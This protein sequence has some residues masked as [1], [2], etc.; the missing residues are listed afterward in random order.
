MCLFRCS[1]TASP[2]SEETSTSTFN[3]TQRNLHSSLQGAS[4]HDI[5]QKRTVSQNK[6]TKT[7][8]ILDEKK[9]CA[10]SLP[11][12]FSLKSIPSARLKRPPLMVFTHQRQMF[13]TSDG[14]LN[15]TIQL[16]ISQERLLMEGDAV[17]SFL[18]VFF[19]SLS[20]WIATGPGY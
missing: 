1:F 12:A 13:P 14:N 19:M 5:T 4:E 10:L 11:K 8:K 2:L 6:P 15:G 9:V 18:L 3:P 20:W 17:A 7:P 16:C